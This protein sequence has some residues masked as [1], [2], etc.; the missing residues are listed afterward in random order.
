MLQYVWFNL[1]DLWDWNL[2]RVLH[3]QYEK[4]W[5]PAN[6]G[7][8]RL[9]PAHRALARLPRRRRRPRSRH[10]SA[11]LLMHVLVTGGTGYVGRFIV[12]RHARGATA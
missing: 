3:F 9:A 6:P 4:P 2:I 7:L 1:P 11:T 8:D 10:A 5:D 12:P